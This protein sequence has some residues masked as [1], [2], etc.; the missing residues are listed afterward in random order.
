MIC[1]LI[2]GVL[3]PFVKFNA[4]LNYGK[5]KYTIIFPCIFIAQSIFSI[6][7]GIILKNSRNFQLTPIFLVFASLTDFVFYTN[8]YLFFLSLLVQ[9]LG[10]KSLKYSSHGPN[11][12]KYLSLQENMESILY[13]EGF[14]GRFG[15]NG[16][17]ILLSLLFSFGFKWNSLGLIPIFIILFLSCLWLFLSF[18]IRIKS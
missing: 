4:I 10:F 18:R 17:A 16:M 12:E 6:I 9:Y 5:E 15:K 11:K 3:D 1:G 13:Y 7:M 14:A 2:A 8:K